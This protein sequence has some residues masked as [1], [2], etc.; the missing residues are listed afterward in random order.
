VADSSEQNGMFKS[1]LKKV[2][3][4]VIKKKGELHLPMH[5][6]MHD[7]V[8][9]EIAD[10]GWN[11]LTFTLL[12]HKE[13]VKEINRQAIFSSATNCLLTRKKP[14]NPA[15]SMNLSQGISKTMLDKIVDHEI[16]EWVWNTALTTN[17]EQIRQE[18]VTRF[19]NATHMTA[20]ICFNGNGCLLNDKVLN[21]VQGINHSKR[22]KEQAT[23]A[24]KERSEQELKEKVE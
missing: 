21:R 20:G 2:K 14:I 15:E 4:F 6:V 12:D 1:E 5:V 17:R 18:K 19:E 16:R 22:D 8:G 13:L 9:K 23:A 10:R 24:R 3:Q 7:I 11:P